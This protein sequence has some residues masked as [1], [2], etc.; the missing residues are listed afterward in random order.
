MNLVIPCVI[1]IFQKQKDSLV[2][3]KEDNWNSG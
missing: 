3:A 1:G 2:E